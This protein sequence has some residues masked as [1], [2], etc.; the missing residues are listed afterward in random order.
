MKRMRRSG[1]IRLLTSI[2]WVGGVVALLLA[3]GGPLWFHLIHTN[4]LRSDLEEAA[5]QVAKLQREELVV[6][7]RFLSFD[8]RAGQQPSFVN[9]GGAA[10]G[11]L[12]DRRMLLAGWIRDD[13]HFLIRVMTRPEA[14]SS[15]LLP[16]MLLEQELDTNGKTVRQTWIEG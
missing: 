10:T 7:E 12:A 6:H 1:F 11:F 15:D 9:T 8:M 5:V 16:A 14:I 4:G 3:V 13:G 2:G